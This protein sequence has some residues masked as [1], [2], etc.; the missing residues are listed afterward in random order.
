MV[1]KRN[2]MYKV[3][4]IFE[5]LAAFEAGSAEGDHALVWEPKSSK[6]GKRVPSYLPYFGNLMTVEAP[7]LIKLGSFMGGRFTFI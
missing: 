3:M 6:R 7:F 1:E 4:N 5:A 2:D